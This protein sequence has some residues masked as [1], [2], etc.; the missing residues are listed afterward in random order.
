MNSSTALGRL[1]ADS[2]LVLSLL[3]MDVTPPIN[4]RTGGDANLSIE[5]ARTWP[6]RQSRQQADDRS[7][8]PQ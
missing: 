6:A 8:K 2:V 7:G 4:K 3:G 5:R 1:V